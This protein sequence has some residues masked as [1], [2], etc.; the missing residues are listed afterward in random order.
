MS[1]LYCS[2]LVMSLS[3]F[4]VRV[5]W[6]QNKLGSV[7]SYCNLLKC[8]WGIDANSYEMFDRI[9]QWSYHEVWGFLYRKAHYW[10]HL[11]TCFMLPQMYFWS[12]KVEALQKP[13]L[14]E[15]LSFAGVTMRGSWWRRIH[16]NG[17]TSKKEQRLPWTG[18]RLD[19]S[20]TVCGIVLWRGGANM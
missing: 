1:Y 5:V 6:S 7:L 18:E 8:S 3:R 14:T 19:V 15:K 11:F 20:S 10:F 17:A 12:S 9:H 13:K 16:P 2:V 4:H